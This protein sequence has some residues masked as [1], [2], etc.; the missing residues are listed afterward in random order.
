[1][2]LVRAREEAGGGEEGAE[3]DEAFDQLRA[4]AVAV[5][6]EA[7]GR[8]RAGLEQLDE[9]APRLQAMDTRRHV[10]V[11]RLAQLREEDLLLPVPRKAGLPAVEP[12]LADGRAGKRIELPAQPVEPARRARVDVPR[13]VPEAREHEA[14]VAAREVGDG[15]PVVLACAVHEHPGDARGLRLGDQ[16]IL[17]A[18]EA[19]VLQVVVRI[20]GRREGQGGRLHAFPAW[21]AAKSRIS[22]QTFVSELRRCDVRCSV[23]PMERR[24]DGSS[25]RI[26]SG[27]APL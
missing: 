26:S 18:R 13:V 24:N 4:A 14:G 22:A 15:G 9:T 25:A 7:A 19:V 27:A 10:A 21:R 2:R 1:M 6:D 17:P 3:R 8:A 23:M 11:R 20:E 12:D 5:Q 16:R